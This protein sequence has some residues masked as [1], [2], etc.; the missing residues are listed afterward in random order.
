MS[1]FNDLV[2][3]T[4]DASSKA[5]KKA[6]DM[7]EISKLNSQISAEEKKI[8]SVCL[9][10]GEKYVELHK[11]DHEEAFAEMFATIEEALQKIEDCKTQIERIKGVKKCDKCGKEVPDEVAFCSSCGNAMPKPEPKEEEVAEETKAE[12]KK[13]TNCQAELPEGAVFCGVCG[14][15]QEE[16]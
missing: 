1:F 13:C 11:E 10:V 5:V 12:P 8:K 2:Q 7:T 9:D 14:T 4:S 16:Q 3:K 15:K 6:Q